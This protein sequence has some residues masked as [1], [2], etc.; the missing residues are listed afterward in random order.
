[1]HRSPIA[2]VLPLLA[3]LVLLVSGC[4]DQVAEPLVGVGLSIRAPLDTQNPFFDPTV[5]FV[6]LT[7]E[8]PDIGEGAVQF[9]NPYS[10]GAQIELGAVPYGLHRQ[11][12]VGLWPKNET[13]G[14]PI[15]PML[16]QGRT[17]PFDLTAADLTASGAKALFPY[18]TRVNEFA[19]AV[20]DGG[21]A[22]VDAR[23]GLS[24]EELPDHT[25]MMLGGAVPKPAATNPYDLAS[26][27]GFS[28]KVLI[29][30]ANLRTIQDLSAVG[31]QLNLGRAFHAS[32]TGIKGLVVVSGGYTFDGTNNVV[33]NHVEYFD[34]TSKLFLTSPN[35][36]AA[37]MLYPRSH[38]TITRM[39]D[40][41]DYFLIVGGKGPDPKAGLSWEIWHPKT[42]VQAQGQLKTARWNHAA[43][44]LPEVDGGFIML[45]GGEGLVDGKPVALN[46]FE[47]IRYDTCGNV[48]RVGNLTVTC[49]VG[50]TNYCRPAN[51]PSGL[52][53]DKCAAL[54][55][56]NGYQEVTWE[57]ISQPLVEGVGRNLPG[58]VYVPHGAYHYIYIVG[59]FSDAARTKPLDRIDIFDI[60]QG[61]WVPNQLTLDA[62]R[63]A[64]QVVASMVG[65]RAGQVLISGGIGE[66]GK[67]VAPAEVV[68]VANP[69]QPTAAL[70][71]WPV[72]TVL[73]GG[74]VAGLAFPLA[75]GH[76]LL[77]GG[78]SL[79][80]GGMN[81]Q[82]SV[83]L[84]NPL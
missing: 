56:Q 37:H 31:V 24:A 45:I 2:R 58:A 20:S 28:D 64:P 11:L 43:V 76:I 10:P 14:E 53:V 12:R 59:G 27:A 4:S 38:H 52:G 80:G 16:A 34:P 81:P 72:K 66:D 83:Q 9:V 51:D 77:T 18:V 40:N 30:D 74:T 46:S 42:G 73:P 6:E 29:Y 21:A 67:T 47:V 19:T 3:G 79:N 78:A 15:G 70:Q 26:Y 39:F 5:A 23:V 65:P 84:Y 36:A 22:V 69:G 82:T 44:R 75:T 25:V 32:A 48:A 49:K 8:G 55:A 33:S 62:A 35:L 17:I 61:V 68:Y 13:S 50:G 1:M 71:K 7:A 63:G 54:K 60:Q 57:P 41:D